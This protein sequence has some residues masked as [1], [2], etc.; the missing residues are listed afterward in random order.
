MST[1][2]LRQPGHAPAALP[3]VG[4]DHEDAGRGAPEV[5]ADDHLLADEGGGTHDEQVG[6]A[7]L[8][9][10][11]PAQ[12]V[13]I[14]HRSGRLWILNSAGLDW[15]VLQPRQAEDAP[16]QKARLGF[17]AKGLAK[18]ELTDGLGQ[19][20]VIAF[21]AWKHNPA[22]P[23]GTFRFTPPKGV[24]VVGSVS[25]AAQVTPLRD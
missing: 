9:A 25:P 24:D 11:V 8:D 4:P 16:F 15:L 20:T 1:I 14:Q 18:M 23:A 12:P 3:S 6:R 7:Q 21:G 19:R 5:A 10:W 13:R 17:G 22:F 2:A